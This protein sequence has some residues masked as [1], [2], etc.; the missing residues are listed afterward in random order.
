MSFHPL[1]VY[2]TDCR[3]RH[4][5]G[6]VTPETS[7]Y[8]PLETLLST[9]GQELKK[10]RVRCFMSL[11]NTDGNMPDGGLFTAEQIAKLSDDPLPGQKP[12]RGVI[13]AKPLKVDLARLHLHVQHISRARETA[14]CG[15]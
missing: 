13:E 3:A 7:Y 15:D 12:A 4:Q 9:V 11:K 10:P 14:G 2:L 5:T 8:G 1:A 6:A